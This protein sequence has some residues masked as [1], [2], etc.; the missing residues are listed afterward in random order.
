MLRLQWPR[1]PYW[2]QPTGSCPAGIGPACGRSCSTG[3][4][5]PRLMTSMA[6]GSGKTI[7]ALVSRRFVRDLLAQFQSVRG[8]C[9]L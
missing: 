2:P 3:C 5:M 7:A 6:P 1:F 8:A 4:W 9:R